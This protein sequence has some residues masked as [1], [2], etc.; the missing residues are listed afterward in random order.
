MGVIS[1]VIG[2]INQLM[3]GGPCM[4]P[5][6]RFQ[7]AREPGQAALVTTVWEGHCSNFQNFQ[8]WRSWL[9]WHLWRAQRSAIVLYIIVIYIFYI[10]IYIYAYIV[11][12]IYIY[13]AV[14]HNTSMQEMDFLGMG[15]KAWFNGKEVKI[16]ETQIF[17]SCLP[18]FHI[19]WPVLK[20][21][22]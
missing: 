19:C 4:W 1:I 15:R 2:T 12:C 10:Y 14:F 21:Q 17:P 5:W 11:I 20:S 6:V 22:F 3:T 13:I 9:G 18:I 7:Q 8:R 16:L